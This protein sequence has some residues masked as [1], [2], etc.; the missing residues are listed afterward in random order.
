MKVRKLVY[1][2]VLLVVGMLVYTS[3]QNDSG[4]ENVPS[5][6]KEVI[7]DDFKDLSAHQNEVKSLG[8]SFYP[9]D[10][11]FPAGFYGY[12]GDEFYVTVQDGKS[13][14]TLKYLIREVSGDK[15][16]RKVLRYEWK[17]TWESFK[18]PGGKFESYELR[19]NSWIKTGS[20]Q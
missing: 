15:G 12:Q 11:F 20:A 10:I 13:V 4:L 16:A 5:I 14:A 6:S 3:G 8:E 17:D 18:P 7:F 2:L 1:M 9:T 19:N